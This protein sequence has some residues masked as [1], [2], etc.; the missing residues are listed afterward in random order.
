MTRGTNSTDGGEQR[1]AGHA[2]GA[3]LEERRD[4]AQDEHDA[5]GGDDDGRV[6]GELQR[7]GRRLEGDP[8]S[9]GSRFGG[10]VADEVQPDEPEDDPDGLATAEAEAAS[11]RPCPAGADVGGVQRRWPSAARIRKIVRTITSAATKSSTSAWMIRTESIDRPALLLH[12]P[13]ARQHRAP[14]DRGE[15]D[16]ERVGAGEE[17]DGDGV[18][19][20]ADEHARAQEPVG[21]RD[22]AG[23]GQAGEGA[24][25]RPSR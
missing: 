13:G 14:Q 3:A 5:D 25:Q 8:S 15:D 19:A 10:H 6:D 1:A 12:E 20:D 4:R 23:T 9:A 21:A 16:A 17:R 22:L 18:E 7:V 2:G 11:R 24:R